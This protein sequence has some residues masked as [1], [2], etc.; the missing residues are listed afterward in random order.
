MTSINLVIPKGLPVMRDYRVR[1]V[2]Q[3]FCDPE[4]KEYKAEYD[5]VISSLPREFNEFL[6][7]AHSALILH[8]TKVE[9]AKQFL[10][11]K[12][13]QIDSAIAA[14]FKAAKNKEN[15]SQPSVTEGKCECTL[16]VQTPCPAHPQY[17]NF[18][19]IFRGCIGGLF[20]THEVHDSIKNLPNEQY[21]H[22]LRKEV[23]NTMED[24]SIIFGEGPYIG[25][26]SNF[27]YLKLYGGPPPSHLGRKR[28]YWAPPPDSKPGKSG[29]DKSTQTG[30]NCTCE[31]LNLE[32]PCVIHNDNIPVVDDSAPTMQIEYRVPDS[33]SL[34]SLKEM[35]ESKLKVLETLLRE[36][37]DVDME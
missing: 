27:F 14:I 30:D 13:K 37:Q 21:F 35:N 20:I 18:K 3:Y 23:F 26:Y 12:S 29:F 2:A 8:R 10:A 15:L 11:T 22:K 19:T 25:P 16:T 32:N 34:D 1:V 28:Y 4:N 7:K 33:S 9:E 24:S 6:S 36:A 31:L 5:R 17:L